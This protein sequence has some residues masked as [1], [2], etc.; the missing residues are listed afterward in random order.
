MDAQGRVLGEGVVQM[1]TLEPG[2]YVLA[3]RVPPDSPPV[4]IRP[5]L[6]GTEPPDTGPPMEVVRRYLEQA[7]LKTEGT[8]PR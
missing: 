6:A 4:R 5:V 1:P 7:G 2:E 8:E 3:V